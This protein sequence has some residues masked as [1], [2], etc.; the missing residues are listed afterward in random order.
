[1]KKK[2]EIITFKV[3]QDLLEAI[4]HIPN[5]SE[6]IRTAIIEALGNVCPLCNGTGM[7]TPS[8]KLH[9]NDFAAD[10]SIVTCDE[11]HETILV[12]SNESNRLRKSILK[13]LHMKAI[14]ILA[15]ILTSG[16]ASAAEPR[17]EKIKA[18]VSILPQAYFV[19]RVG[20]PY[21]DVDVL[22]VPGQSPATYEPTPKQMSK[23]GR[24]HV[25]FRIGVPF[26]K[27]FVP[28]ISNTCKNL[29]IV[30]T[31]KGVP[32]RYFRKSKGSQV[33][34]PHI[35]LDPKLVKIQAEN[36][37]NAL[38]HSDP[39]HAKE[40]KGNLNSFHADLDRVDA[41]IAQGSLHT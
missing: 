32:L 9:W 36:I 4:R 24:S 23:L 37:C 22:V 13:Y 29:Q 11:C 14:L 21:V 33:P 2:Q 31:R 8:Q 3:D 28:K 18:F 25:Y 27:A 5:R 30:D 41:K 40:Y 1:M 12:C 17:T 38:V 34:D 20:G 39:T 16:I 7:L 19:E 10:H 26:E 6:F 35:W 15:G